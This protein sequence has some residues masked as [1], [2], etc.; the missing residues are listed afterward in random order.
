MEEGERGLMTDTDTRWEEADDGAHVDVDRDTD[1][2]L[3]PPS[4]DDKPSSEEDRERMEDSGVCRDFLK[5]ADNLK[6]PA[7][8]GWRPLKS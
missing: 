2:Y 5:E 4:A 8:E 7:G 3:D 6:W 1:L